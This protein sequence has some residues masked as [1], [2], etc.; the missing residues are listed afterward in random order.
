MRLRGLSLALYASMST[1]LSLS[2]PTTAAAAASLGTLAATH[3]GPIQVGLTGSIGMG[4]STIS[5]HFKKLGFGVFDADEMVHVLYGRDGEA[6]GLIAEHFPDVVVDNAIDR[7]KLAAHV[8]DVS[9][10]QDNLKLIEGIVH[11]LVIRKRKEFYEEAK[12]RGELLVIYD[13]P[14][15]FENRAAYDVDYIIVAT[16]A[17][18]IQRA[19]CLSR[20]GMNEEK[21][22][23]I[24]A[25]Q[26]PD[27]TKREKADFLI[28]TDKLG[29]YSQARAQTA[30]FLQ[31]IIDSNPIKYDSW[32]KKN[33]DRQTT[34]GSLRYYYDM[35]VFDIDQ[36]LCP[37]MGPVSAGMNA[38][39]E[40]ADTHMPKSAAK[41]REEAKSRSILSRIKQENPLMSHDFTDLRR[42]VLEEITKEY[43][44]E[45]DKVDEGMDYFLAARSNIEPYLYS[46]SLA[47]ID[48]IRSEGLE[49]GFLTN[50][51]CDVESHCPDLS[52]KLKF[53]LC[54]GDIGAMKP[55]IIPFLAVAQR[56][57]V[58]SNRI[59]YV[60][61]SYEHDV[62]GALAAGMGAALLTRSDEA[63]GSNDA[64]IEYD[65][66][67][68]FI[69]LTSLNSEEMLMKIKE[70]F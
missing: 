37:V 65:E 16:A 44:D 15:L 24:L 62:K 69:R 53:S 7:T 22:K 11:P 21:L 70:F 49:V 61:D 58:P 29:T 57:G 39:L 47:C 63:G 36:T 18:E 25:K 66:E 5:N 48:W 10:G 26:V 51:N 14:L 13:I 9:S 68:K 35:I 27:A 67:G 17:E 1:S 42:C 30:S 59:L 54:A 6:V 28:F 8:L 46:D 45:A 31:Q 64:L 38:L 34:P 2:R 60:G 3:Q 56:S 32:M 43:D 4:K 19:R 12:Q 55:S 52:S 20:M 50:G 33:V 40:Y 23:S 41:I